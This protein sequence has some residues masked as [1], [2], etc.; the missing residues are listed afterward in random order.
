MHRREQARAKVTV[1]RHLLIHTFIMLRD[2]IDDAQFKLRGA[3]MR[4]TARTVQRPKVPGH[5]IERPASESHYLLLLCMRMTPHGLEM[6][7]WMIERTAI[8][9]LEGEASRY[10][11][12]ISVEAFKFFHKA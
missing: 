9:R 10:P 7:G 3:D 6:P 8:V 5:L 2:E 1:A 11:K 4:S 12:L